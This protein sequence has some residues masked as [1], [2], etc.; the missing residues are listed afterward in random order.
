M[1]TDRLSQSEISSRADDI[2]K[3]ETQGPVR[4]NLRGKN[5][6]LAETG[7]QSPVRIN[8]RTKKES[9]EDDSAKS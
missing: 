8:L 1:E 2:E 7:T 6:E 3:L 4:I 5:E 9:E